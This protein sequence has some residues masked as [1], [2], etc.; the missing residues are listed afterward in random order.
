[1]KRMTITSW[2]TFTVSFE[3]DSD[4]RNHPLLQVLANELSAA[5]RPIISTRKIVPGGP[6][7]TTAATLAVDTVAPDSVVFAATSPTNGI[8]LGTLRPGDAVPLWVRRNAPPNTD[9]VESDYFVI[10]VIG[11]PFI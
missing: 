3:G 1:M 4:K 5:S 9:F 7:N 8:S 6:I 2:G 11:K 10:K